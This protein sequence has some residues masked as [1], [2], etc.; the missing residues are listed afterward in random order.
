MPYFAA[1]DSIEAELE[2]ENGVCGYFPS[3]SLPVILSNPFFFLYIFC[4][5]YNIIVEDKRQILSLVRYT[6]D[7]Q[8]FDEKVGAIDLHFQ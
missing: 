2:W 7:L 4:Q 3:S 1:F 6:S 8:E 5:V